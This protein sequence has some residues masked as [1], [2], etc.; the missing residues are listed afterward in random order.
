M[1]KTKG[2]LSH[3]FVD[4]LSGMAIGLFATLIIGTIIGQIG[5]MLNQSWAFTRYLLM[6][7]NCAKFIMGAGIGVGIA[8]KYR[9]TP[10]VAVSAAV[11][12]MVGAQSV[13]IIN[14]TIKFGVCG[15]PLSAF[16]AAF[17]AIEIGDLVAGK[18]NV[19]IIVT[20][21][22]SILSGAAVGLI[23]GPYANQFMSWLG[24]I[25][26]W[27]TRQQPFLMGIV[28]SV[29]M[30]IFLTLP[31]SSAAIGVMLHLSGI[32][33]G[34]AVVGCCCQMVGF[35]VA[36]Y[37][38]NKVSGLIAQGLGTSML[39]MPNIIRRPLIWIPPILTSAILGPVSTCLVEITC[40]EVGAGMG[41]SGLVG[42]IDT[43][44]SMLKTSSDT[45]ITVILILIMLIIAP[46][47]LT[48]IFSEGMRRVGLIKNG[49]MSLDLKMSK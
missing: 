4:G 34:A 24:S 16:I 44:D 35:A 42:V 48:L 9:S 14:S 8:S 30:G 6:I 32:S 1:K 36:S 20:P 43:F 38:E 40:S 37:R 3:V 15:D 2:Y 23:V 45:I 46:A 5:S 29:L 17:V 19:D 25:I 47:L 28:I 31:I 41:T 39:Q 27:A 21:A 7:A 13:N 11:A 12:G 33:A 26:E 10:L 22:A 49:D 18:T